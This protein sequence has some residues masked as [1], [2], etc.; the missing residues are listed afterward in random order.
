MKAPKA[1]MPAFNCHIRPLMRIHRLMSPIC[2]TVNATNTPMAYSGM[3]LLV[4]AWKISIK[5]DANAAST[6]IPLE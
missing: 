5:S 2:A 4:C 6:I 3:R 1:L